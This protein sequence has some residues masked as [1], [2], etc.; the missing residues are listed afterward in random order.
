MYQL[1][2]ISILLHV[3]E[4]LHAVSRRCARGRTPAPKHI[5]LRVTLVLFPHAVFLYSRQ[6]QRTNA[7]D[8]T[9]RGCAFVSTHEPD[10]HT[11]VCMR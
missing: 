10:E 2:Q 11:L 9:L 1:A 3:C 4:S 6:N 8:E 5:P 7:Q